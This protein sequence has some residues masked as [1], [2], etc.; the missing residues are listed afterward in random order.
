M[1]VNTREA[2]YMPA[3]AA[4]LLLTLGVTAWWLYTLSFGPA[5]RPAAMESLINTQAASLQARMAIEGD[6]AGLEAL[7]IGA[8]ILGLV[9]SLTGFSRAAAVQPESAIGGI[10]ITVATIPAALMLLSLVPIWYYRLDESR[11]T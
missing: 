7:E 1:S 6:V 11:L 4:L 9:L 5:S 8:Q 3:L 10:Y 2:R